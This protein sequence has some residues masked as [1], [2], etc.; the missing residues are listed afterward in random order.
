MVDHGHAAQAG[1][2]ADIRAHPDVVFPVFENDADHFRGQAV[3]RSPVLQIGAA[4]VLA[5]HAVVVGRDVKDPRGFD[6]QAIDGAGRVRA[7][8]DTLPALVVAQPGAGIVRAQPQPL[9][10]HRQGAETVR[11]DCVR[12]SDG[13][14]RRVAGIA[15]QAVIGRHQDPLA[16]GQDVLDY[17]AAL[18]AAGVQ[19]RDISPVEDRDTVVGADPYPLA[20]VFGQGPATHRTDGRFLE[21][22]QAVA[23]PARYAGHRGDPQG[24]V[25]GNQQFLDA[26]AVQA[27]FTKKIPEPAAI[28]ARQ[29]SPCSHPQVAVPVLGQGRNLRLGNAVFQPQDLEW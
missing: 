11:G 15:P 18:G 12:G 21:H 22:F 20:G 24:A 19:E 14:G 6:R 8:G 2:A 26:R 25:A 23:M 3:L 4:G 9:G 27:V 17:G 1:Q 16:V 7:A 29:P 28:E 10:G 13:L 5:E